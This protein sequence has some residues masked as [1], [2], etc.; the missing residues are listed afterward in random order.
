MTALLESSPPVTPAVPRRRRNGRRTLD[1]IAVHS[2]ALALGLMFT[3]PLVF[4]F[5]T[6][7]MSDQ[8]ALSSELWPREWHFENFVAVF[9]K[10]PMF[11]YLTNS[12]VYSVLATAGMLLSSIPAAYAL[13]RF[14]WRGGNLAFMLVIAAMMLPPQVTAV[15][16]YSM[17]ASGHL[18]GTLWPLIV[19]YFVGDAFSIFLLRQFF[20]TIPEDYLDA[21]RMDGC[22]EFQVL[23]RV[24]LPMTKPGI[25][26]AALFTFLYTWNDYFGPLLYVGERQESWT[27]SVALASFR[28]M[29]RT[30]QWNLTM[31]ATTLVLVPV[32]VLFLFAQKSFVRGLTFTG[33]K[34]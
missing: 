18:T 9:Q 22:S 29:H 33:I 21:A 1:F 13:A 27:L 15:P 34:G 20:L 7:V 14:R 12:L 31:A 3:L 28:G 11:T 24:L 30:T 5:L 8:Q 32:V 19:P 26:A 16:L 10:A 23:Y 4:V 6:A 17:W 25:A 2:V